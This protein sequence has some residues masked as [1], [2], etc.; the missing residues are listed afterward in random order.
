MI[1]RAAD[2]FHVAHDG[3]ETWHCFSAG[4]H[5]D[6]DNVAYGPMIGCDEHLVGPGAGFDW[7]PHR[8]VEIVSWVLSGV[9]RHQ[10]ADEERI[11]RRVA[12]HDPSQRGRRLRA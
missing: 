12:R 1:V 11:V 3:I 4:A 2:R 9:L 8:G 10:G 6:P 7:H 5:Y